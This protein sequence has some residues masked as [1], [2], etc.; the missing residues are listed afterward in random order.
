MSYMTAWANLHLLGQPNTLLATVMSV[1][2]DT[3]YQSNALPARRNLG[4]TAD[5]MQAARL[6]LAEEAA[7]M[8]HDRYM[9]TWDAPANRRLNHSVSRS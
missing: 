5:I 1:Q 2:I 4:E 6:G 7:W 8:V 9:L 3:V